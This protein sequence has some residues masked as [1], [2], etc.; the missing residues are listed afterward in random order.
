MSNDN[1]EIDGSLERLRSELTQAIKRGQD[2]GLRAL[3][4]WTVIDDMRT[5]LDE[6][7]WGKPE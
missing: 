4:I 3:T 6:M 1:R 5:A 7:A 2:A